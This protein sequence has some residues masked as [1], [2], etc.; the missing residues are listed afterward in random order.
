MTPTRKLML[1]AAMALMMGL[2]APT[3]RAQALKPSGIVAVLTDYGTTDFYVGAL[4]GAMCRANPAV[5]IVTITN[6]IEAYDIHEGAYVLAMAAREFPAG[7]VFVGVVDPGV[8]AGRKCIVLETKSGMLFVGPDNGLFTIVARQMGVKSVHEITNRAMMRPGKTSAT[9]QGR[10]VFGPVAA[11]LAGGANVTQVGPG[12]AKMVMLKQTAA[13]RMKSGV[14]CGILHTDH[15][16]NII[17]NVSASLVASAGLRLGRKVKI[18]AGNKT[19]IAK[20]VKTY[21]DVPV[22]EWL[23]AI[24]A[25]GTLEI[26]RNEADAAKSLGVKAGMPVVVSSVQTGAKK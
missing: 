4:Y 8:G 2:T 22:G 26:A 9:F 11:R 20:F 21:G 23:V 25:E 14:S 10:D 17:T 15:Y 7:T 19:V 24:N 6:E 5:H 18:T 1:F 16:G 3:G 12:L 13:S